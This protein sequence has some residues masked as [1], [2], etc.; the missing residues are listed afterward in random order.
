MENQL[1]IQNRELSDVLAQMH[2]DDLQAT[3]SQ[4]VDIVL[5][6]LNVGGKIL[7]CGNGGS[8]AESQ[9]MAAEYSATLSSSNFRPGFA[10]LALTTDTSFVTAWSNDFGFEQVFARQVENLASSKDVLMAYSTSGNSSNVRLACEAAQ[11][12]GAKVI[13]LLG[14]DGGA[15]KSVC[16][17]SIVVPSKSTPRIQECHTLI[18]HSICRQVE[19]KLGY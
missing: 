9:H 12:A 6:T 15:I 7:F 19:I 14:G 11:K 10:A 18:G 1:L 16:T 13:G 8:A 2:S 4:A 5:E 17:T 3:F